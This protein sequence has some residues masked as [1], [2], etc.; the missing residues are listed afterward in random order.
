[1]NKNI[2]RGKNRGIS[3]FLYFILVVL[4]TYQDSIL[5]KYFSDIGSSPLYIGGLL[6]I[7]FICVKN[8]SIRISKEIRYLYILLMWIGII[9]VFY[10]LGYVIIYNSIYIGQV[11]ILQKSFNIMLTWFCLINVPT[12][13]YNISN[14]FSEKQVFFPFQVGYLFM[15]ALSMLEL[16][17]S[18]YAFESLHTIATFP[19]WRIRLLTL[20]SSYTTLPVCF[21]FTLS[22][23]YSKN[24]IN[25]KLLMVLNTTLFIYFVSITGAKSMVGIL[26]S[27]FILWYFY[28]IRK[29]KKKIIKVI[30]PVTIILFVVV[31]LYSDDFILR[32][33]SDL[34]GSQTSGTYATRFYTLFVS[35]MQGIK[36]PFGCGGTYLYYFQQNLEEYFFILKNSSFNLGLS[37]VIGFIS[38]STGKAVTA[39]SG[40]AQ[41]NLYWGVLGSIYF[42]YNFRRLLKYFYIKDQVLFISA[43]SCLVAFTFFYGF[44]SETMLLIFIYLYYMNHNKIRGIDV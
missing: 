16:K 37:E 39:K 42:L 1:M 9:S 22:F 13:L 29:F 30:I 19:Y 15:M 24:I 33:S 26:G 35:F 6:L 31:I 32:L 2:K 11:N 8:K 17:A 18:P 20:E 38:S 10:C 14:N 5:Y 3:Y 12:V 40:L 4:S 27:V 41:Y 25:N 34:S 21:F 28:N 7:I 23:Y 43:L 36:N 44:G